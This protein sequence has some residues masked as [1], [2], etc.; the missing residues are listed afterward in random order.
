MGTDPK[1]VVISQSCSHWRLAKDT[2]DFAT[3]FVLSAI[4]A[5]TLSIITWGAVWILRMKNINLIK[6]FGLAILWLIFTIIGFIVTSAIVAAFSGGTIMVD[7]VTG[8]ISVLLCLML[9]LI[10]SMSLTQ[11]ISKHR[12]ID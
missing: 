7:Q 4:I 8:M 9:S 6:K 3:H 11:L 10:G 1:P 5:L 12:F 2:D